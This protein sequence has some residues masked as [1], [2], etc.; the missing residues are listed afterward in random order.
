MIKSAAIKQ[1]DTVFIGSSHG[2]IIC[3]MISHKHFN[4]DKPDYTEGF[5]DEN[6]K[7]FNRMEA[8]KEAFRCGQIS[9]NKFQ[10]Y[11]FDLEIDSEIKNQLDS[12]EEI[13]K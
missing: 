13:S 7:F 1:G 2:E 3:R 4:Y 9:G 12:L 8:A 5:V 6:G 11:S 10:L